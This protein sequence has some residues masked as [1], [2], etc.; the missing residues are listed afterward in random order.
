MFTIDQIKASFSKTKTGA[1]FPRYIQDIIKL[2]VTGYTTYVIDGH[3]QY[4]GKGDYRIQTDA[5]YIGF[6][7]AT[8][9]DVERFK[10]SL[11]AHQQ[12]HTDFLTFCKDCAETGVEKWIV[13]TI[14]MTCTYFDKGGREMLVEEIPGMKPND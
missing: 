10:Q 4:F 9:S 6:E 11:K 7:I 13:D 12:G 3:T 1:D 14:A 5:R 2:G 8:T